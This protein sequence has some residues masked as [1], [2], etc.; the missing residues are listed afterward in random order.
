MGV[1]TALCVTA[2]YESLFLVFS[3]VAIALVRRRFVVSLI[4]VFGAAAPLILFGLIWVR[5]GGW[6]LP[7]SLI[8]KRKLAE[9]NGLAEKIFDLT[10]NTYFN[11]K[12]TAIKDGFGIMIFA[13]VGFL[14]AAARRRDTLPSSFPVVFAICALGATAGHFIFA[15]V[16]WLYRYESWLIFLDLTAVGLLAQSLLKPKL[17][18]LVAIAIIGTFTDRTVNSTLDVA[19]A[20]ADRRLE[21]IAP[22]EFL[23]RFY[24]DKTIMASDVGAVAWFAP[25]TTVLDIFGLGSNE[26]VRR[27]MSPAGYHANDVSEW[28]ARSGA[29]IAILEV[30]S[31]I[32]DLVPDQWPLVGIVHIPRNVVFRDRIVAFF[33]IAPGEEATL[34]RNLQSFS[35]PESVSLLI[36][37]PR[38][39][40]TRRC[41]Q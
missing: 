36:N 32:A 33:A 13:L 20:M 11:L 30:C 3:A 41:W 16:G 23:D 4:L 28:A 21:H 8:L 14:I 5:N 26:P 34:Q 2:R 25:T 6:F 7:N 12:Q 15:S 27:L 9:R 40:M 37:P 31:A 38:S 24:P 17:I 18:I 1:L 35:F 22:A 10:K 39:E 19:W 29:R